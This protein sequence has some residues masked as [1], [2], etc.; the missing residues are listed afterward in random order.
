MLLN[1][2]DHII[3]QVA[4]LLLSFL[5][6]Y[7]LLNIYDPFFDE[8]LCLILDFL[9]HVNSHLQG[10][11][12]GFDLNHLVGDW[13]KY[14]LHLVAAAQPQSMFPL[15]LLKLLP[16]HLGE[17]AMIHSYLGYL[18]IY[19]ASVI[20]ELHVIARRLNCLRPFVA[21]L[22]VVSVLQLYRRVLALHILADALVRTPV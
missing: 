21:A 18:L 16:L 8:L 5:L 1:G 6:L 3:G 9:S 14:F 22:Q 4:P 12:F 7:L 13:N 17:R 19:V 10:F 11:T 15:L 20:V 2:L